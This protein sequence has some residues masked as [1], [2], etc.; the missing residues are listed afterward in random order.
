MLKYRRHPRTTTYI[1]NNYIY[2]TCAILEKP[3]C[4]FMSSDNTVYTLLYIFSEFYIQLL[5][6]QKCRF[7]NKHSNICRHHD[8]PVQIQVLAI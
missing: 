1:H 4:S 3:R 6:L 8:C 7:D 2:T 5:Y